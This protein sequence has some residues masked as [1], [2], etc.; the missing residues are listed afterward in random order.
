MSCNS[1]ALFS[2]SCMRIQLIVIKPGPIV[3]ISPFELH[4]DDSDFFNEIYRQDGRWHKYEFSTSGQAAPAGAVF[5]ADHDAHKRRRMAINPFLSKP[6][7]MKRMSL[8]QSRINLLQDRIEEATSQGT[9]FELGLA[10]SAMT[11]DIATAYV[12]GKSYDSLHS[13][14]FNK[15]LTSILQKAGYLWHVNKHIQLSNLFFKRLLP[16]I[17]SVLVPGNF[18]PFFV[19]MRD[20]EDHTKDLINLHGRQG[21][22]TN[23]SEGKSS[24]P[25]TSPQTL[26]EQILSSSLPAEEKRYKRVNDEIG[27]VTGAGFETTS[28]TLRHIAYHLYSNTHIL[29]RLRAELDAHSETWTA[30]AEDSDES[31]FHHLHHHRAWSWHKLSQLPYLKGVVKEGLRLT[32]G[33]VSRMQR[34]AEKQ[35]TYHEG[36]SGV[37]AGRTW[38]IPAGVPVGMSIMSMH[39]DEEIFPQALR[40]WPERW[41]DEAD[42]KA[43]K[44]MEKHFAPFSRGTR[45]CVGMQ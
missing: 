42:E 12:L 20:C 43:Q 13:P 37:T 4:I 10:F 45:I 35:L 8:I 1:S 44:R 34:V 24:P 25:G 36:G 28:N 41:A 16:L 6:A 19:F 11:M 30:A 26:V 3:R 22:A 27:T 9:M 21:G 33:V 5:T 40:F 39:M 18:R 29:A 14:A 2:V 7:V 23:P 17:P 32:P 31:S 15:E 38:T